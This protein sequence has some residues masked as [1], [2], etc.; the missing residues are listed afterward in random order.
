MNSNQLWNTW[1][2]VNEITK[3][4]KFVSDKQ[5]IPFEQNQPVGTNASKRQDNKATARESEAT[6]VTK[7]P[8]KQIAAII[9]ATA[10]SETSSD[11]IDNDKMSEEL[12]RM[13]DKPPIKTPVCYS[14]NQIEVLQTLGNFTFASQYETDE[15]LQKKLN[16]MKKPDSTKKTAS[17]HR[18]ERNSEA[19]V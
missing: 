6:N 11:E 7:A 1:F 10:I 14:V 3:P 16:L 8:F 13:A 15:F 4:D 2:T 18:G 5:K 9:Q 12:Q 19:L 17:P